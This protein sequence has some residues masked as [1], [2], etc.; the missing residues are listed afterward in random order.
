MGWFK[1]KKPITTETS[2][3]E[4]LAE[5]DRIDADGY[6]DPYEATELGGQ[7][8]PLIEIESNKEHFDPTWDARAYAVSDATENRASQVRGRHYTEWVPELDSMRTEGRDDEALEILLECI[9]A[10]ERGARVMGR[11]PA[12]AYTTRAAIIYRR[13]KDY[14]SEVA[15]LERWKAACPPDRWNEAGKIGLRLGKATALLDESE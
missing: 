4:T 9:A 14:A 10:A 5:L 2:R 6:L 12:P 7:I 3:Q 1:R 15:I 8:H 13:R 11:Q